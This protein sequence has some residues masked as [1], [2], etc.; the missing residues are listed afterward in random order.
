MA[1]GTTNHLTVEE[2]DNYKLDC[3]RKWEQV[4][5]LQMQLPDRQDRW[6]NALAM[7][8]VSGTLLTMA[9]GTYAE[10][11]K[12]YRGVNTAI[13]RGKIDYLLKYCR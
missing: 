11:Y 2:L 12:S 5:F 8:G 9:D 7:T 13:I 1:W 6:T 4:E 3:N 10:R